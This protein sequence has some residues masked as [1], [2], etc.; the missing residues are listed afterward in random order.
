[1]IDF[2]DMIN[3]AINELV[4]D[5]NLYSN[6]YDHILVDEYQDISA[7]RYKLIKNLLSHNP[8]CKL[9]CVGDDWQNIMGFAGSNLD[10]IVNFEKYFENPAMTKISTNYR[11]V[12]TI[13]EAGRDLIENNGCCQIAK[14]TVSKCQ[15]RNLIQVFKS[16]HRQNYH[17]RYHEQI[18]TDCLNRLIEYKHRSYAP[19]D[20]LIL[21]RFIRTHAYQASSHHIVRRLL[22]KAKVRGIEIAYD[23][24]KAASKIRLLSVHKSKGL[25]ARVVFILDVVEGLFG[26]PCEIEDPSIYAPAREDYPPQNQMEEERRLFYVAMSRAKEDLVIY[27]REK[28]KSQLI[29]EISKYTEENRLNY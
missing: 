29:E 23:N 7:Q 8:K 16:P 24:A 22:H 9:F 13:V 3:Q 28:M 26:F 14:D 15:E 2:E 25:E 4:C 11:S 6:V 19:G 5:K 27:T 18:A 12:G 17:A 10:Y 20:I 21:C 1:M